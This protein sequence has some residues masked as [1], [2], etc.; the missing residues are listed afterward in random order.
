MSGGFHK[1]YN[2]QGEVGILVTN[3]Y[4]AGWYSWCDKY[5]PEMVFDKGM[6]EAILNDD[7]LT[8][9]EIAE[10]KYPDACLTAVEDLIVEFLPPN[11]AFRIDEFDGNESIEILDH[12]CL[13]T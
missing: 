7:Y 1:Y 5:G 11:T 8:A 9:L 10:K 3:S 2:K 4:G 12:N 13:C 6:V